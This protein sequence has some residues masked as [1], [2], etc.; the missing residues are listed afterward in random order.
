ML[1][2]VKF[3]TYYC[4]CYGGDMLLNIVADV[5]ALWLQLCHILNF[6]PGNL[7]ESSISSCLSLTWLSPDVGF[8]EFWF[9]IRVDPIHFLTTLSHGFIK[10]CLWQLAW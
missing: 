6:C 10:L 9:Y 3:D 2:K 4:H 1:Q 7:L 8:K 5:N